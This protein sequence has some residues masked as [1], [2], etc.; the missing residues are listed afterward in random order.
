MC[1]PHAEPC[2]ESEEKSDLSDDKI[3]LVNQNSFSSVAEPPRKKQKTLDSMF[4]SNS[5]KDK[6][7]TAKMVGVVKSCGNLS[8]SNKNPKQHVKCQTVDQTNEHTVSTVE[9]WMPELSQLKVAEW[10][11]FDRDAKGK[12]RNLRCKFCIQF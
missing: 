12:V 1:P 6:H 4:L 10:L 2:Y 7:K 8:S 5:K 11:Q 3:I 9:G